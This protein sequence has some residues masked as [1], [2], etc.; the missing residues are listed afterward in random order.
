[1]SGIDTIEEYKQCKADV[2]DTIKQLENEKK[3]Q[4]PKDKDVDN[5]IFAK[6]VLS[7]LDF[8]SSPDISEQAKNEALRSIISK[9]IYVKPENRLDIIF[10]S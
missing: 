4:I 9:I 6:K 3:A 2:L 7:V 10:Y 5:K 1:M 8:I